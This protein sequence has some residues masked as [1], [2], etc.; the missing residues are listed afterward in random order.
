MYRLTQKTIPAPEST[1]A[2]KSRLLRAHTTIPHDVLLRHPYL[3]FTDPP[4]HSLHPWVLGVLSE[5]HRPT[6]CTAFR[7]ITGPAFH[8][9]Y[10][11][12][13]RP[14]ANDTLTC[15]EPECT[16]DWTPEHYFDDGC[17]RDWE[18]K[19]DLIP[20]NFNS[21]LCTE[22]SGARLARVLQLTRAFRKPLPK[23]RPDP[24]Y[25]GLTEGKAP[26]FN[27]TPRPHHS[28]LVKQLYDIHHTL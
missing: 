17:D 22:D 26:C 1:K 28:I 14:L 10:S 13:F 23:P 21:L 18:L 6:Q 12:R 15:P 3:V 16:D 8:A 11:R 5:K 27:I 7:L 19:G 9:T 2:A 25:E 20:H 24:P 4:S